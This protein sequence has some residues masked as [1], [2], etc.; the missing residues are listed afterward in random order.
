MNLLESQIDNLSLSKLGEKACQLFIAKDFQRLADTFGYAMAYDRDI[1]TAIESDFIQCTK[2]SL[3][4]GLLESV[5]IKNFK[6][7]DTGLLS[8]I[9]C[10]L[11]FDEGRRVLI[12]LIMTE[13]EDSKSLFLEDITALA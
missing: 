3:Q 4:C 6:P 13:H 12:E 7:N 5:T 1:A 11:L 10:I 8:A 9:E 2:N